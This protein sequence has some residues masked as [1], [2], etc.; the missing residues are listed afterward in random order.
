MRRCRL[1]IVVRDVGLEWLFSE[2]RFVLVD[3]KRYCCDN[4]G[5]LLSFVS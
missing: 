3:P 2:A 4:L 5:V 1:E